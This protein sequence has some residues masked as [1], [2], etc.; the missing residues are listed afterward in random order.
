MKKNTKGHNSRKLVLRSEAIAMLRP[1]SLR[2]LRTVVGGSD[3]DCTSSGDQT[4][5]CAPP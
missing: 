5:N 4:D 2:E 1:L 3:P